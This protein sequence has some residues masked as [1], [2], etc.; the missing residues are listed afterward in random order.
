ME[1][2]FY[3]TLL[4]V[5]AFLGI[6]YLLYTVLDEPD[7]NIMKVSNTD[8]QRIGTLILNGILQTESVVNSESLDTTITEIK[9]RYLS[10]LQSDYTYKIVVIDK[11]EINAFA[12]PGGNI[13]IYSGLVNFCKSP[14]ELSAV[15]AHEIGHIENKHIIERISREIGVSVV[16]AVLFNG[17]AGVI[18]QI[19]K[20][21]LSTSFDRDEEREADQFAFS[22]MAKSNIHPKA[23]ATFFERL[24]EKQGD[25][26]K[27]LQFLSTHPVNKERIR[28]ARNYKLPTTFREIKLNHT[29]FVN[30]KDVF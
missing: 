17:D 20:L 25:M 16:S 23:L 18:G 12:L 6:W 19:S 14:E 9:D 21:I 11:D 27:E 1:K 13:I 24:T 5:G 3:K 22:L 4:L 8:E 26:V 7:K 15:I 10:H 29:S 28:A 30:A 2:I